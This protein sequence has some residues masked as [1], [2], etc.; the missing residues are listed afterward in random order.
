MIDLQVGGLDDLLEYLARMV[1]RTEEA[2]ASIQRNG[3]DP[4]KDIDQKIEAV[5]E[6][7]GLQS[8]TLREHQVPL[9]NKEEAEAVIEDDKV[10]EI[11]ILGEDIAN[12]IV[13]E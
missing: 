11:S 1:E 13:E 4:S 12:E 9:M 8:G 6:D 2:D 3:S 5:R 10:L 7:L